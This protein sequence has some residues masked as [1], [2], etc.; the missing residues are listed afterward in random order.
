MIRTRRLVFMSVNVPGDAGAPSNIL[1]L[2]L[3]K[4]NGNNFKPGSPRK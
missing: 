4:L 2:V 1:R 3:I